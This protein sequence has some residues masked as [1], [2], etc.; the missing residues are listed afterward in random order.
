[1]SGFR[2]PDHAT[3]DIKKCVRWLRGKC[4]VNADPAKQ[5][6]M[7]DIPMNYGMVDRAIEELEYC[8]VHYAHHFADSFAVVAFNHPEHITRCFAAHAYNQV[9]KEKFHFHPLT[10]DEFLHRHRDKF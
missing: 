3:V 2:S 6:Y 10:R 4:Q 1:M 5:G 9:A 8:S 7:Q